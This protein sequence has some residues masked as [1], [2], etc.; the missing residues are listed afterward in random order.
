[1]VVQRRLI[2]TESERNGIRGMYG[3]TPVT[4][5]NFIITDWLSPDEKYAIFLDELY[6]ITNKVK[7]GNIWENF[8]NFKFFIKH[9]FE[10][11]E[12]VPSSIKESINNSLNNLILTESIQDLT[13]IKPYIKEMLMTEDISDWASGAGEWLKDTAKNTASN[14]GEFFEKSFS[15][16]QKLISGIT[17]GQW[18]EVLNLIKNGSLYVARKIREALYS[19]IGLILDAILIATGIG[20][21]AQFVVWG[22][23]VALDIYELISGDYEN[24]SE[25]FLMRLLFT[26]IDIIGLV[27]A[28]VAAKASKTIIGN[29]VRKFGTSIE[30]L[31]KAAKASPKFKSLLESILNSASSAS[32]KMGQ[33]SSFLKTK[34]PMLYGFVSKILGSLGKFIMKIITSIKQILSGSFKVISAPGKTI[35]KTL[36]SGTKLGKGA[37]AT[38]NTT[39]LVGGI[40]TYEKAGEIKQNKEIIKSIKSNNIKP[41]FSGG[42]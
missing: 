29:I 33:V 1:M 11:A 42:L 10:V 9:S 34:S 26:G 23:V 12:N 25:S 24:K 3:L 5:S 35:E 17:S 8:D 37:K 38:F 31:S 16:V 13:S 41:T 28:G 36:G 14:T 2:I 20:K 27:S 6:D 21:S 30:G 40:G 32:G 18:S 15:G 19:P 4:E 22:I 7:I 39:S